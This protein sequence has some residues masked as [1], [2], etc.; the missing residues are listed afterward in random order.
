MKAHNA[1]LK[2]IKVKALK[3]FCLC[4]IADKAVTIRDWRADGPIKSG[5]PLYIIIP[6]FSFPFHHTCRASCFST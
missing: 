4:F 6:I 3:A 2:E 1:L 5:F